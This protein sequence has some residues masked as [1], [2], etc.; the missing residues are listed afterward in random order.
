MPTITLPQFQFQRLQSFIWP[1]IFIPVA[2]LLILWSDVDRDWLSTT[3]SSWQLNT[4]RI[5]LSR[6][7]EHAETDQEP[8]RIWLLESTGSHDEVRA[9]LIHTFG[10]LSHGEISEFRLMERYHIVDIMNNFTLEAPIKKVA[11]TGALESSVRNQPAPHVIVS[12]T[13]EFD[14]ERLSKPIE[15]LLTNS[16]AHIFCVIHHADRW[17]P[18]KGK[19]VAIAQQWA[20][21]GRIDFLGLSKHTVD[22]FVENALPEWNTTVSITTR[23]YPPVFPVQLPEPDVGTV[24][25][26]MQGDY[27]PSRR[28]YKGIFEDLDKVIAKVKEYGENETV[29]LHLIGHGKTPTVPDHVK[30]HVFFDQSLSYPDFYSRL[31]T[32]F[33]VLPAFASATYLDRKASSSIPAALIAGAPILASEELLAA[34]TY[35]PREAAW[36]SLP[37][38]TEMMA[39]ERLVHDRDE[40]AKKREASR[41]AAINIMEMN[42]QNVRKWVAEAMRPR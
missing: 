29:A 35:L 10:G 38:E 11:G 32:S 41:A 20:E 1:L 9:A 22:Y 28:N 12:T 24:A 31:S 13:C 2:L 40:F 3:L 36:L 34:Y 39:I 14:L 26:S 37:D 5:D 23:V 6:F 17:I 8:I 27:D 19:H 21:K 4:T 25:L 15:T 7:K 16:T 30:D 18:E 42:R 33:A